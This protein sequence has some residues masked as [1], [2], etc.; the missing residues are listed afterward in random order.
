MAAVTSEAIRI[1]FQSEHLRV[2]VLPLESEER[3]KAAAVHVFSEDLRVG[4]AGEY[5]QYDDS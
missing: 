5:G 3:R 2:V 1:F 4:G